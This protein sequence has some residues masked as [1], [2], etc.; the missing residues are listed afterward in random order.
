MSTTDL[1]Y[2]NGDMI[3]W[4]RALN[5]IP[6]DPIEKSRNV[7]KKQIIAWEKGDALPTFN[8]AIELANALHIPFGYLFLSQP[9]NVTTPLPDLRT[10]KKSEQRAPSGN[11]LE[12]LYEVLAKQEWY[13]DYQ[14]S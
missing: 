5:N 10:R 11:F 8:Q 3:V 4:A 1:A 9:P 14:L 12:L 7:S 6:Y 13:R 2:I